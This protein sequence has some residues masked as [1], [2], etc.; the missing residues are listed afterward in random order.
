MTLAVHSPSFSRAPQ[1]K[2]CRKRPRK[3][4][5][6]IRSHATNYRHTP[7]AHLG[8]WVSCL[9]CREWT[10]PFAAHLRRHFSRPPF[11][12]RRVQQGLSRNFD[13]RGLA[14]VFRSVSFPGTA[15]ARSHVLKGSWIPFWQDFRQRAPRMDTLLRRLA[16]ALLCAVARPASLSDPAKLATLKTPRAANDRLH[17][18]LAWLEEARQGGMVPSKTIDEAQKITADTGAHGLAGKRDALAN[19][20]WAT[21]R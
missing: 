8:R 19:R 16:F 15:T 1:T 4:G 9:S 6:T 13:L 21:S 10:H 11:C 7:C 5:S 17:K 3:E 12:S 2:V 20:A 18:I 14:A